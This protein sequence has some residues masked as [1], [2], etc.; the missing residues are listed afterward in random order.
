MPNADVV[1]IGSGLSALITAERLSETKNVIIIT[2]LEKTNSN[3]M[4]AQG[5]V[6]AAI[7]KNDHWR[8]H[9]RDTMIAGCE[10]NSEKAV[11]ELVRSGPSAV[12]NLIATGMKFD[13]DRNGTICLGMEGAHGTRRI[14][15]AGGDST[16]REMVSFLLKRLA[17]KVQ[18]IE[19]E[20]AIELLIK[21]N[22]CFGVMTSTLEDH[23]KV[24]YASQVVLATG[25]CGGIYETTS[26][27]LTVTGDG[28]ALAY[29]AGAEL[30][31]L[32]FIQFHPTMLNTKDGSRVL[33][34]EA[35]RGEGA[36]L[37]TSEGRRIM[38]GVHDLKDL[39]PRD[40]V[41]R[42]ID[43]E[44]KKGN[45]VFLNI[46][47]ILHFK[48][49]FPSISMLCEENGVKIEDGFIPV[50]PGAHFLMGGVK[51]D[52]NG[53]T[54]VVNLFAVGEVACSGVHGA[55]RLASNSLLESIVFA[56]KLALHIL[57]LPLSHI[58]IPELLKN[59]SNS[60]NEPLTFLPTKEEITSQM[61][62]NAGLIREKKGLKQVRDWLGSFLKKCQ[63]N[64]IADY[65]RN[66]IEIINMLTV[67]WL[68]VTSALARTESRGGHF[69]SD[70][71][72]CDNEKWLKKQI[73]RSKARDNF[74]RIEHEFV[75]V[76]IK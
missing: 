43:R 51:I 6:A 30:V 15:H 5:G 63:L 10:H 1:I 47:K 38:V 60:R 27:D 69:R 21:N 33:I 11:K 4:L 64:H 3:S 48:E 58:H 28:I 65:H 35:V 75:G 40:I 29:R 8:L 49:R 14:L 71:P 59:M 44:V 26:N 54:S 55:N 19:G 24:Y 13:T 74:N 25:G 66:Q 76:K 46:S 42:A 17:G 70:Y 50:S 56:N 32:E 53:Q 20:M 72:H 67:S 12:K 31:D 61:M 52:L 62:K 23:R 7:G 9:L 57:S 41:A 34:S 16:G 45:D 22:V 37:V 68:I 2:K 73:V 39:A 18:I 36:Y